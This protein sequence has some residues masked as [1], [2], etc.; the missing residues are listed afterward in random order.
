MP[1][2]RP[3]VR[4]LAGFVLVAAAS[5]QAEEV[6]SIPTPKEVTV[7]IDNFTFGPA[8]LSIAPGTTVTWVNHDD[9]PHVVVDTGKAFRS[10]VLDTDER[11]S[12]TFSAPGDF[13]YFCSLHPHMT[14]RVRVREGNPGA[15][16]AVTG[17]PAP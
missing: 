5:V 13:T 15:A 10:R 4:L 11:F 17:A 2:T 1:L 6:R 9:I 16:A 12:F 7:V 14:G 3:T 8:D